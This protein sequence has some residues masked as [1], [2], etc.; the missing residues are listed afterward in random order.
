MLKTK[1]G[2]TKRFKVS[3]RG[4]IL[5]GS[6]GKSHLLTSKNR[7]RLRKLKRTGQIKQVKAKQ[8]LK[9]MMPYSL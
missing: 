5:Y 2:V 7:K 1:K 6:S 9:L 3:K 8:F 4:K